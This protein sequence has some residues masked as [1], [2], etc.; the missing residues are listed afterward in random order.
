MHV[1]NNKEYT[2]PVGNE[3]TYVLVSHSALTLCCWSN[4]YV[5]SVDLHTYGSQVGV[6]CGEVYVLMS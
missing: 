6:C 3:Y 1:C 4:E 5:H 2:S